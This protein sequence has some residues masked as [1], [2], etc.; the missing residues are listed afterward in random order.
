MTVCDQKFSWE[1]EKKYVTVELYEYYN[2]FISP[3][4]SQE[5]L[6]SFG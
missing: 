6:T 3:F 1:V 5:R 4:N 2:I